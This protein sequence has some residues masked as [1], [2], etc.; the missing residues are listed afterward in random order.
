MGT[1]LVN[2][3][4]NVKKQKGEG[5]FKQREPSG[6]HTRGF[7]KK[8]P[9]LYAKKLRTDRKNLLLAFLRAEGINSGTGYF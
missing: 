5:G 7:S 2:H 6:N 8:R 4:R 9:E 3:L 1:S